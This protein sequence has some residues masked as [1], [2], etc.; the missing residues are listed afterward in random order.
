MKRRETD[1]RVVSSVVVIDGGTTDSWGMP[2]DE[3]TLPQ[4]LQAN[5]YHTALAGKWHVSPAR[6]AQPSLSR[7]T[8][9]ASTHLHPFFLP[10]PTHFLPCVP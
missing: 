5:G 4:V 3:V 8:V 10:C 1:G 7:M 2:M 6:P 9:P